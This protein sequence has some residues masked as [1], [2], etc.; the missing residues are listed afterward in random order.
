MKFGLFTLLALT[1][2]TS[3]FAGPDETNV[4]YGTD[5]RKDLYEVSNP[6]YKRLAASTAGMV[7]MRFFTKGASP[8]TFD[9]RIKL[10]LEKIENLCPNEKFAQ[11]LVGPQCSGFLVGPDTLV[12]AGHC[13]FAQNT[14]KENC[15]SAVWVF[16]YAMKSAYSNPTV[17]I[18]RNNIYLCKQVIAGTFGKGNGDFAIV[19]LDRPVV[20]RA[21]LK[22]RQ[23]GNISVGTPLVVIGHPSALP[24]KISDNAR[25]LKNNDA[26]I[27]ST[28]LDTFHGN[29]GSP[30]F[31]ARTGTVEGILI[32]GKTDYYPSN[33]KDQKSCK[34][35]NK[36]DESAMNCS[37]G[38]ED[39]PVKDGEAVY[40]ITRIADLIKKALALP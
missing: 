14:P 30:V 26:Q 37:A 18:P 32:M 6:L 20:G 35:L 2:S 27:F 24:Q 38:P 40:R 19:K 25:V 16:D 28:N 17:G 39:G 31:D 15:D 22:F 33:P 4:V 1:L 29:S 5:N 11:Q 7:D 23:S 34:H 9:F 10:T 12:T 8:S 36:C 13:Y 21:P 3:L